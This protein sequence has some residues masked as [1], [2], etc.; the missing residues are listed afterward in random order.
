MKRFTICLAVITMVFGLSGLA[1][2]DNTATGVT[3]QGAG[4]LGSFFVPTYSAEGTSAVYKGKT[5][6]PVIAADCCLSGDSYKLIVKSS[7]N[8]K[9]VKWTSKGTL[10]SDCSSASSFPDQRSLTLS[11]AKKVKLKLIKAPAGLPA[12]AYV[13]MGGT[14]TQKKGSDACGY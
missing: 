13:T 11:N 12:D 2:A 9:K 3:T 14:W 6:G 7:T 5:S 4:G 8:K 1:L 10:K